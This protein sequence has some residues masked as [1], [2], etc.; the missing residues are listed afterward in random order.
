MRGDHQL[1]LTDVGLAELDESSTFVQ[2]IERG[3]HELTRQRVEH[4]VHAPARARGQE[5][6]SEVQRTG[7]RKP[8]RLEPE[9]FKRSPL[10]W[11]GR[12][13]Y[14]GTEMAGDLDRRHAHPTRRGVYQ[15]RLA[16]FQ[17]RKLDQPVIDGQEH[18]R[19]RRGPR[20]GPAVR[21]A[22]DQPAVRVGD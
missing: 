18:D 12:R 22:H 20:E 21:H 7:G 2:Q 15:H 8:R 1:R 14:L 11:T 9:R 3:V 16:G 13:K 5:L 17:T 19:H 6:L 10:S 4:D